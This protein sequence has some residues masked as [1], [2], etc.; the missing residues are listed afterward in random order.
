MSK[1]GSK[2]TEAILNA[3]RTR[4]KTFPLHYPPIKMAVEIHD[5]IRSESRIT[6]PYAEIKKMANDVCRECGSLLA[7]TMAWS[8]NPLQTATRLAIAGNIIDCG[9]YG[10]RKVSKRKLSNVVQEVLSQSLKGNSV[11]TF[12]GLISNAENILYIGDNAGECFFDRPLLDLMPVGKV[13][14]AVRG[15]PVLNDATAEDARTAGIHNRCPVIDTGDDAPGILLERCSDEFTRLFQKSD[16]IISKGQGNYES[17]SE[18]T[19]KTIVFLTKVKC[20]VIAQDIGYPLNS[21]V[22]KICRQTSGVD[23]NSKQRN[24]KMEVCHA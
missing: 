9:V 18:M 1:L 15:G 3:V 4:I 19:D 6:D 23:K 20:E 12:C 13:A 10:L 5:L 21:N 7:E 8:L 17:L 24:K 14:Y 11:S 2:E 16:L 22:I